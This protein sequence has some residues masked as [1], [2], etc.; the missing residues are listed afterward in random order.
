MFN[1]L[2]SILE[3]FNSE[4][5]QIDD[6]ACPIDLSNKIRILIVDDDEFMRVYLRN[7]LREMDEI[8]IVGEAGS[9]QEAI[10]LNNSTDPDLIVL[11]YELPDIHGVNLIKEMMQQKSN[12]ILMFSSFTH[13]D[14]PITIECLRSGAV[15]FISKSSRLID[16]DLYH[17]SVEVPKKIR[18]LAKYS[19]FE[20]DQIRKRNI[21]SLQGDV[22]SPE[23]EV[24]YNK[25][26]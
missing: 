24:V 22:K 19:E 9:G 8:M 20:L 18:E 2:S 10:E 26:A 4:V 12:P 7:V 17:I 5:E 13:D 14:T 16:T 3:K 21:E 25:T 1:I 23:N 11:D 15:D 6:E